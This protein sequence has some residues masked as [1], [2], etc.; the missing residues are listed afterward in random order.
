[1]SFT[2]VINTVEV[3]K[4]FVVSVIPPSL[5]VA[6]MVDGNWRAI[7]IKVSYYKVHTFYLL[8]QTLKVDYSK[9]F[10]ELCMLKKLL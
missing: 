6:A 4:A 1:M 5:P 8:H 2:A 9:H 7:V 10:K 3:D